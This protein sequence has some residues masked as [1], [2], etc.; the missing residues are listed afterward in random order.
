MKRPTTPVATINHQEQR[1][2][3]LPPIL[4]RSI[5][6]ADLQPVVGIVNPQVFSSTSGGQVEVSDATVVPDSGATPLLLGL[7]LAGLLVFRRLFP[8]E[9]SGPLPS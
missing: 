2:Q 1:Q 5:N 7:G 6:S 8:L 4:D 3:N 9:R